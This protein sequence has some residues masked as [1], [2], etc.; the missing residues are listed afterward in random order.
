MTRESETDNMKYTIEQ[1]KSAARVLKEN[2]QEHGSDCWTCP[3][4]T[5]NDGG[6]CLC[7]MDEEWPINWHI[8][9]IKEVQ[10]PRVTR[11]KW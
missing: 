2:C 8:D 5:V 7:I 4:H 3:L 9:K 11:R 10:E 1:L 6:E